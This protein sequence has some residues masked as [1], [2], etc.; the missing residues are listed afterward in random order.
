M[1]VTPITSGLSQVIGVKYTVRTDSSSDWGSVSNDTYFY[2]V[3][4]NL[5][6]YKNASGTVVKVF[7][8][9]GG[10]SIYT[11][12][13]TLIG[14][15]IVD[16]S[17]HTLTLD[18]TANNNVQ[19]Q[20]NAKEVY[21]GL[22]PYF[23]VN[24]N[25]GIS[26]M[27]ANGSD[28]AI[29]AYSGNPSSQPRIFHVGRFGGGEWY[30]TLTMGYSSTSSRVRIEEATVDFYDVN[31]I[32]RHKIGLSTGSGNQYTRFFY[33]GYTNNG[34]FIIGSS[35]VI[36]TEKISL[37][38]STL[39][40]GDGT[41][42]GTTLALYD[43]DTTPSKT[44]EWLDNGNVNI[45]QDSIFELKGNDLTFDLFN[46]NSGNSL[47]KV[48]G[49]L[50][51]DA[52][53]VLLYDN[54]TLFNIK[55]NSVQDTSTLNFFGTATFG[56]DSNAT[57]GG[58][59][60]IS[61]TTTTFNFNADYA[62]KIG[63]AGGSSGG[64]VTFHKQ[65]FTWGGF[66]VGASAKIGT[67]NISLQGSTL[68]K[69]EGT[70]TGT[71]L[72]LY[73][74]DTTPVKKWDFLDNG[75][76][77]TTNN[78]GIGS[79]SVFNYSS[80]NNTIIGHSNNMQ[81]SNYNTMIGYGNTINSAKSDV[82]IVG[83]TITASSKYAFG[84]G[85]NLSLQGEF[86]GAFGMWLV[87]GAT[88]AYAIGR[89]VG[90]ASP[91]VNNTANSLALGWD[92]TTPQY[93]FAKTG[94]SIDA[95]LDMSNNRILNA[96]INPSVQ[97]AT[98]SATFTINADQQSDGVLTAMASATTIASPTGTPVQSQSLIFRFKDDGTARA[99][100]WNAIFRAIGITLPT[101]TTASKLLYVGCKYNSTDTKWDVVSVQEEA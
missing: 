12:D 90:T 41:S 92:S 45:G 32:V 11:A 25:G 39:I 101:T 24:L 3:A 49:G 56:R 18:G 66:I 98:S 65:G 77:I 22:V 47:I 95:D 88:G 61:K 14:D 16:L 68:I 99:I 21:T 43:N 40:K 100:T 9:G 27:G 58:S 91:L 74:N 15:R 54:T 50:N 94:A 37:Q 48:L 59:V 31:N 30:G 7:E 33:N 8:E 78:I 73:N 17:T 89:G 52:F 70:S 10:D 84:F 44:W 38:G 75:T 51:K 53:T 20:V 63:Y 42:T 69:G 93:L 36:S 67:E 13:G 64:Q 29:S 4:T 19:F 80:T 79:G 5:P 35:A 1:A 23:K 96:I 26:L 85:Q 71:T 86:G 82:V 2:D 97:E 87:S 6:Y 60:D 76:L 55:P 57:S 72:A 46:S 81:G 62:H 28:G 83:T 34:R